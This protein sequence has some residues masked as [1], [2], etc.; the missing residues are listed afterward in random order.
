MTKSLV[1]PT[2][3]Q[4]CLKLSKG[5]EGTFDIPRARQKIWL[6]RAGEGTFWLTE[7]GPTVVKYS[8]DV[9]HSGA[10][11]GA[12]GEMEGGDQ[13]RYK[14]TLRPLVQVDLHFCIT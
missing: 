3:H 7:V 5:R 14:W 4:I 12:R 6:R 8:H 2:P 10:G 11:C 1:P 9:M 13:R